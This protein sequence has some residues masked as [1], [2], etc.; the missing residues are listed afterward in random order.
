MMKNA[1]AFEFFEELSKG[2]LDDVLVSKFSRE[3]ILK[4]LILQEEECILCTIVHF[5]NRKGVL[6]IEEKREMTNNHPY[7]FEIQSNQMDLFP[8]E[9]P[10]IRAILS[11]LQIDYDNSLSV[12]SRQFKNKVHYI[13]KHISNWNSCSDAIL[14]MHYYNSIIQEQK[15]IFI[16]SIKSQTVNLF[17][18]EAV[19]NHF[20]ILLKEIN[21]LIVDILTRCKLDIKTIKYEVRNI[22]D[23]SD[24]VKL[25]YLALVEIHQFVQDRSKV[26]SSNSIY[27]INIS[28]KENCELYIDHSVKIQEFFLKSKINKSLREIMFNPLK[29]F[30]KETKQMEI[31]EDFFL[32]CCFYVEEILNFISQNSNHNTITDG[33]IVD[34]LFWLNLNDTSF[35]NYVLETIQ[36]QMIKEKEKQKSKLILL[37]HFKKFELLNLNHRYKYRIYDVSIKKMIKSWIETELQIFN[38]ELN[39]SALNKTKGTKEVNVKSKVKTNLSLN[40]SVILIRLLKESGI[41]AQQNLSVIGI[42]FLRTFSTLSQKEITLKS[43]KTKY[44]NPDTKSIEQVKIMLKNMEENCGNL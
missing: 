14:K 13:I 11:F 15:S 16:K 5:V 9:E 35:L 19:C 21:L 31:D 33:A 25:I 36:S 29:E 8:I 1:Y 34:L 7:I 17:D 32:Y 18:V 38:E 23:N 26:H 20:K 6:K 4:R 3:E 37:T 12:V 43:F 30:Q 24:L 39:F 27:F 10:K 42:A 22:F 44:Y 40:Q 28:S 2:K 41:F